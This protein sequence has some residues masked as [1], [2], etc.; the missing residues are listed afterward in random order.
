MLIL[1]ELIELVLVAQQL[2]KLELAG[3]IEESNQIGMAKYKF[4]RTNGLQE[5]LDPS[6]EA[7]PDN[8]ILLIHYDDCNNN[9]C[10]NG[11]G[12]GGKP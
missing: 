1:L 3:K 11:C 8:E 4:R 5:L 12:R 6:L 2:S 9:E 7:L 10:A